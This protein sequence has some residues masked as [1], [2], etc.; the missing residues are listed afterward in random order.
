MLLTLGVWA[1]D[2]SG[3]SSAAGLVFLAVVAPVT[4][5]PLIGLLADRVDRK[6]LLVGANLAAAAAATT[7]LL[8][9]TSAQLW[10]L[11]G[12]AFAFGALGLVNSA[13]QSG[14]VRDMLPARHLDTANGL[15]TAV[16]QGLRI[17][18]PIAGSAGDDRRPGSPAERPAAV[19]HGD[20][21]RGG[22]RRPRLLRHGPV[23]TRGQG[24]REG[25]R[26]L[27]GAGGR[28]GGRQCARRPDGGR[29]VAPMGTCGGGRDLTRAG[30]RGRGRDGGRPRRRSAARLRG[31]GAVRV[32]G[33]GPVAGRRDGHHPAAAHARQAPGPGR[34]GRRRRHDGA[35]DGL[36]RG[37]RGARR[38]RRLPM[39][40]DHR[41]RGPDRLR[42]R[43]DDDLHESPR[44]RRA[45]R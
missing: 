18:S 43:A 35:A 23:R 31:D 28:S 30:R 27:R 38:R 33:G 11:Y 42:V 15:L 1:K 7:L 25:G 45:A 10:L 12:V 40:D 4:P 14:L 37:R 5:S 39:A 21:E 29:G 41:R 19:A 26:V 8:V 13:A 16:D 22:V 44:R 20:G 6:P 24:A 17:L 3:S 34:R 2:L 9:Q 36:H 32:R